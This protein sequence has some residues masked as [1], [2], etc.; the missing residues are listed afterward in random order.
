QEA[1]RLESQLPP[2]AYVV[3]A[4]PAPGSKDSAAARDLI[5][6]SDA[7]IVLKTSNKQALVYFCNV[8]NGAPISGAQVKLWER[9]HRYDRVWR[10]SSRSTNEDGIAVFELSE[11]QPGQNQEL[12]AV[13]A[14]GDRQA[15]AQGYSYGS[16]N[17]Q[18]PWRIYAFTDR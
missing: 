1:I 17:Q 13:A 12:Y 18:Q 16:P 3:E 9:N 6:V 11:T 10:E 14:A 2:G 8:L 4:R 15:F 7:S 5:L